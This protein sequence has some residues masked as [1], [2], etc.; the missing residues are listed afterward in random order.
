[1]S[2]KKLFV[3]IAA[4]GTLTI[5]VIVLAHGGVD[6][7][8]LEEAVVLPTQPAGASALLVAFSPAWWGILGVSALLT[9]TLSFGVWKFL[10]VP[11]V[12]STDV[13][14]KKQDLRDK[15]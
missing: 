3:H 8:H 13:R 14:D 4:F 9:A 12:K 15:I 5:P 10:Q 2:K 6:D 11:P 1:M 7:G